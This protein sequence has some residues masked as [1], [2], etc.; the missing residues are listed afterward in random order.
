MT[1]AQKQLEEHFNTIESM[2]ADLKAKIARSNGSGALVTRRPLPDP[3]ERV[4][5]VTR[6]LAERGSATA[7]EVQLELGVSHSTAMRAMQAV[8]RA[9]AGTI[10]LEPTGP[11]FR[12]RL[13]HPDR[14]ILDH[15]AQH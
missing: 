2:L 13:W 8:A 4:A 5:R 12:V 3:D 7:A 1:D 15:V 9:K 10:V 14:V 11:T 6:M